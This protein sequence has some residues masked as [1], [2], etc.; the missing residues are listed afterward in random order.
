MCK[1][2]EIKAAIYSG[3]LHRGKILCSPN[4]GLQPLTSEWNNEKQH[5]NL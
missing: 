5:C 4:K 3:C 1:R 2:P